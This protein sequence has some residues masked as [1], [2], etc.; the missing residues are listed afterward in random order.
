MGPILDA[1]AR[2]RLR[3]VAERVT[4]ALPSAIVGDGGLD[5]EFGFSGDALH[6]FQVRP[7]A[8]AHPPGGSSA[9]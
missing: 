8:E 5:L 1:E 4:E 9:D 7:L 3:R 2:A 6:L